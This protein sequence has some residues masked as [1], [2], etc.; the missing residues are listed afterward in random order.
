[1]HFVKEVTYLPLTMTPMG[2]RTSCIETRSLSEL[3]TVCQGFLEIIGMS[4]SK[5]R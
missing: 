1:M 3:L 4:H 2:L 5:Q